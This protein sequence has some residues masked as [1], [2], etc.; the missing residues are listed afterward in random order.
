MPKY[1]KTSIRLNDEFVMKE[2]SKYYLS[3]VSKVGEWSKVKTKGL[4]DIVGKDVTKKLQKLLKKYEIKSSVNF[5][6][7][8]SHKKIGRRGANKKTKKQ[9]K[10]KKDKKI[11]GGG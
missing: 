7:R 9:I 2:G 3:G 5:I 11:K 8:K 6:V 4:E 10:K 1:E